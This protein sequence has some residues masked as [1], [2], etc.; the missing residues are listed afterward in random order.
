MDIQGKLTRHT[1]CTTETDSCWQED[2]EKKLQEWLLVRKGIRLA[3]NKS[4]DQQCNNN[5]QSN[6]VQH[7]ICCSDD[8]KPTQD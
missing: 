2:D 4:G 8:L 5:I 3:G 7:M 1:N 6:K